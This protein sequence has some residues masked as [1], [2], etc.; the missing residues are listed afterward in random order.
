ME[1][2]VSGMRAPHAAYFRPYHEEQYRRHRF[3]A[4]R[5]Q[6]ENATHRLANIRRRAGTPVS[7][8]G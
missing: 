2:A 4:E 5:T 3:A 1:H 8:I 7:K 6:L